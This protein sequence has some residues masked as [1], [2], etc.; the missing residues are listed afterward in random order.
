MNTPAAFTRPS[1]PPSAWLACRTARATL[2]A[3]DMSTAIG[4][5]GLNAFRIAIEHGNRGAFARE[6]LACGAADA[7]CATRDQY[8]PVFQ[9]WHVRSLPAALPVTE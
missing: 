1:S 9:S 7:G 3:S 4:M 6:Q 2:A 8:L 5:T